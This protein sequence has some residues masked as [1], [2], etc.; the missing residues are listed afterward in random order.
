MSIIININNKPV[1]AEKGEYI[2]DTLERSGIKIPTLCHMKGLLPSG[3]CR[4]CLVELKNNGKLVTSCS[5]PVEEGMDILT[6][7]PRVIN[8]RKTIVE[9]LL[10]NHPDDCLFCARNKN[11]ELQNLSEE[12]DVRQRRISGKKNS[13][14]MDIAGLSLV[15]DPDKCILCGRCVREC[16]EVIGVSAIDFSNRGSKTIVGTAFNR[17]LNTSSCVNCGQCLMVCPTGAITEKS[18]INQVIEAISNP[19]LQVMVQY[20]PAISVSLAEEFGLEPG[21][22]INGIMNAAL[23]KVGFNKVFDTSFAADLTIMEEAS[24][25]ID[26]IVKKKP[27]PMFTSC[28]PAWVKY[29]EEFW[30]A[31]IP[32]LSTCKSPQQMMGSVIKNY[33]SRMEDIAPSKIF[34]VAVM[35]CTAKK[36]E[37]QREEMSTDGIQ[38]VDAVLTT[39][40][41][42]KLIRVFGIDISKL[43]PED[44]DSPLGTRTSAGKIFGASGGV[45]EAALRTAHFML[46]GKELVDP[47]FSELR[48]FRGIKETKVTIGDTELGIAVVNGLGY[49]LPVLQ[50]IAAG[51]SNIHFVEVMSC[52]GG[53]IAGGGQH[54][55][56]NQDSIFARI[57]A[58]YNIDE[59]SKV[60]VS[61]QNPQVI[62][63]YAKFLGKPLGEN[64]HHFLHTEY[65]KRE[66]LK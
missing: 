57:K 17:G 65:A 60:K 49:A 6:H 25:L 11:C 13:F 19:E 2:L 54:I 10:S 47:K 32:N 21:K 34:S 8:A 27:L 45:M 29:V 9:L 55:G 28:C 18:H 1:I 16:E 61:H 50:E 43:E 39:R 56:A 44:A 58:L 66:V 46:T 12:L 48:G 33:Y 26:R 41:L 15:R 37:A 30:P 38:D 7:S 5:F 22:D 36:F 42:A 31:M 52:P 23:R 4:M 59:T 53:C 40:E 62:E 64:S 24:E 14:P 3:A 51:R 20:A 63:L 35:P